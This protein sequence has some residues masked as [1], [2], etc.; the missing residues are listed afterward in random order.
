MTSQTLALT[1]AA[2]PIC[3]HSGFLWES[4]SQHTFLLSI[5]LSR[6]LSIPPRPIPSFCKFHPIVFLLGSV[7]LLVSAG[8]GGGSVSVYL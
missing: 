4:V 7:S 1:F 3:L 5:E 6:S 2:A 8:G